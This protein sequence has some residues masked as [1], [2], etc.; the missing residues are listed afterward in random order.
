MKSTQLCSGL[1][2]IKKGLRH[3]DFYR[4]QLIAHAEE[5]I[6]AQRL[7]IRAQSTMTSSAHI[8]WILLFWKRTG[9]AGSRASR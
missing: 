7:C 1:K 2:N 3:D 9:I 4:E 6:E 5:T 8:R